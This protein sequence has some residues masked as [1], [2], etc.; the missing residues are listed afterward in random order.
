MHRLAMLVNSSLVEFNSVYMTED[1]LLQGAVE[2][3]LLTAG[4]VGQVWCYPQLN[5]QG[6]CLYGLEAVLPTRKGYPRFWVIFPNL[7]VPEIHF[8][9]PLSWADDFRAASPLQSAEYAVSA[10]KDV[11]LV[12]YPEWKTGDMVLRLSILAEIFEDLPWQAAIGSVTP[13][14][15]MQEVEA[16]DGESHRQG[17]IKDIVVKMTDGTSFIIDNSIDQPWPYVVGVGSMRMMK[18]ANTEGGEQV[19]LEEYF[20]YEL[21]K[22]GWA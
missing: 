20:D 14:Y 2:D 17:V 11:L 1:G 18:A 8:I 12:R 16:D 19:P 13:S 3:V 9:R 5:G 4:L 21:P 22:M 7:A 6:D 15:G 10:L